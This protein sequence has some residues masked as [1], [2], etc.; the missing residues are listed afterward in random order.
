MHLI[1]LVAIE[2]EYMLRTHWGRMI[3]LAPLLASGLYAQADQTDLKDLLAEALK[4]NPEV[5]AA[6]KRY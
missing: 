6:Q 1:G 4:N 2:N 3:L 5:V